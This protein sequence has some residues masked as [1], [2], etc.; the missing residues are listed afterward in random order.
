MRDA[1]SAAQLIGGGAGATEQLTALHALVRR[2]NTHQVG[3]AAQADQ[4]P[5]C[6]N[7][8]LRI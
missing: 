8:A 2:V 1:A 7:D 6:V 4:K 3:L 5:I